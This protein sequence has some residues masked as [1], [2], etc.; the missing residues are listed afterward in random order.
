MGLDSGDED[1]EEDTF[2]GPPTEVCWALNTSNKAWKGQDG[3]VR[4]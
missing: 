3:D 2:D 1:D 4:A